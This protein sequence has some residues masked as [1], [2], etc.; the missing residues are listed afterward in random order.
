MLNKILTRIIFVVLTLALNKSYAQSWRAA[1]QGANFNVEVFLIDSNN[2]LIVG[3]T[4]TTI[5]GLPR[6]AIA[7]WDSLQ[8][9][10]FGNNA[11][12]Q[13][14]VLC[15]AFYNGDLIVGGAFDSINNL[16]FNNVA[17]WDGNNWQPLGNGFNNRVYTLQVYHGQ[18]YAGGS[19]YF[20]G[21]DTIGH[22]AKWNGAGWQNV[23]ASI[24]GDVFS[25]TIYRDKLVIGGQ[26]TRIN[27]ASIYGIAT[28][29]DTVWTD[30][31]LILN[32]QVY[33]VKNIDDTLYVTGNFTQITG[34]PFNYICRYDGNIWTQ[35]PYPIG[36]TQNVTDIVKYNSN[37]YLC[38]DFDNPDDLYLIN[39]SN[40][41]SIGSSNG[42][43][44]CMAT[45]KNEL[46][47][48]GNFS[49]I[50][51][52][53]TN[54]IAIYADNFFSGLENI[55]K[56]SFSVFPNPYYRSSNRELSFNN[57]N[58]IGIKSISVYSLDGQVLYVSNDIH[59]PFEALPE[60]VFIVEIKTFDNKT[61][62]KKLIII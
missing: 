26:F 11:N 12:F 20:S 21:I 23:L 56:E 10:D 51:S 29:N 52:Q 25:S 13:G 47:V 9:S 50:G 34:Y 16:P 28:F 41:D 49:F 61:Y 33:R 14:S 58:E 27:G 24:D 3:G 8:W 54:C 6:T 44:V 38:G 4:F 40:C 32:N 57:I 30:L 18:L 42:F 60:G 45:Y 19:F 48:G 59:L 5:D 7:T 35:M 2:K 31:D 17:R 55:S 39:G 1:G 36:T 53:A 15:M 37:F 43:Y 22:L 62:T 46:Y